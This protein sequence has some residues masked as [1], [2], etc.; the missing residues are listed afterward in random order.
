M[1]FN[2]VY[3]QLRVPE[4]PS[5]GPMGI[6][7]KYGHIRPAS[8][9]AY[10]EDFPGANRGNN[11]LPEESDSADDEFSDE[12]NADNAS[13][14]AQQGSEEEGAVAMAP[15]LDPNNNIV[16]NGLEVRDESGEGSLGSSPDCHLE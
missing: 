1:L 14:E 7:W 5:I 10:E 16:E 3:L 4:Y 2:I 11:A 6:V 13:N 8:R 9:I 15:A 12:E